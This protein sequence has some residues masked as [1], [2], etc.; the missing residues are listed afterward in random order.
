[1]AHMFDLCNLVDGQRSRNWE[2]EDT[3]G[4]MYMCIGFSSQK[5]E[6]NDKN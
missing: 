6:V 4:Y 2:L 1:M 5:D 3:N